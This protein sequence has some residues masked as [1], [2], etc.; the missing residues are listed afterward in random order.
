MLSFDVPSTTNT[1]EPDP[2]MMGSK[3]FNPTIIAIIIFV[4]L[5]GSGLWYFINSPQD[6]LLGVWENG[7]GSIF[8]VV[9]NEQVML[10]F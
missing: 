6:S 8:L 7:R 2:M 9:F 10:S 1:R 3:R 4:L 5:I